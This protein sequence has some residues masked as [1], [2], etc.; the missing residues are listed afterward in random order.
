MSVPNRSDTS[1]VRIVL[2]SAVLSGLTAPVVSRDHF[3][4]SDRKRPCSADPRGRNNAIDLLEVFPASCC[5]TIP[6]REKDLLIV[7]LR[8]KSAC[9]AVV[10]MSPPQGRFGLDHHPEPSENLYK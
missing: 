8:R 4:G 3:F 2:T 9:F 5:G 7:G 6:V 1:N 10:I